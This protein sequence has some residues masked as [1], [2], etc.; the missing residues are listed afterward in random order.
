MEWRRTG[1]FEWTFSRDISAPYDG[2]LSAI[3]ILESFIAMALYFAVPLVRARPTPGSCVMGYQILSDDGGGLTFVAAMKRACF[4]FWAVCGAYFVGF[5]R[6]DKKNGK[7]WL[8][9]KFGTRAV[10]LD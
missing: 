5:A 3:L 7:F 6:R 8:D 9:L 4:G 1:N 2:W 10:M